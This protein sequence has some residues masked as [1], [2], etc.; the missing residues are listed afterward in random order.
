VLAL[1]RKLAEALSPNTVSI[2]STN[3]LKTALGNEKAVILIKEK[4]N[5]NDF[6]HADEKKKDPSEQK[7]SS[8]TP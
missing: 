3:A 2:Y 8:F 6:K 7:I 4:K 1:Q 5:L